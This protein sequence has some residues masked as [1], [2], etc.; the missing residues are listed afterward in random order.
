MKRILLLASVLMGF[1]LP[2]WGQDD[3]GKRGTIDY[4]RKLQTATGGFLALQAKENIKIA[5]TLKATSSAIRALHYL[6]AEVPNKDACAKFVASCFDKASGGF[7]DLP[8]AQPD[9]FTTAVGMMAVTGLKLPVDSYGPGVIKFLSA[10]AM[11]F[12]DIR[13]AAAGLERLGEKSPKTKA[14]LAEVLKL[15]NPDGTFGKGDG[16]ARATGG[17]VVTLLRLGGTIENRDKVVKAIK[18]GQRNNG[19]F[20]KDDSPVNSDLE[21]TYRVMRCFVMLKEQPQDAEGVRSFVA[22]CRNEDGGYGISPGQPSNA[23]AT[24]FASIVLHWLNQ[25]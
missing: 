9:V 5:P 15:K 16:L 19:G 13:I 23:S 6:G 2:G 1:V 24:Y 17:S 21:T 18:D 14:W 3:P 10:N 20:G 4:V 8:G 11:S 7:A 25:R 12:E 22:K